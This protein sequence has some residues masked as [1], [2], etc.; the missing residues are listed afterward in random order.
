VEE[1]GNYSWLG[2][3]SNVCRLRQPQTNVPIAIKDGLKQTEKHVKLWG[4]PGK[5]LGLLI[6]AI[7]RGRR[8]KRTKERPR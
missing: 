5:H 4:H 6:N 1:S 3:L 7:S 2:S 8:G